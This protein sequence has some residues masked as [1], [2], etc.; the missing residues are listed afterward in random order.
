MLSKSSRRAKAEALGDDNLEGGVPFSELKI[1][2]TISEEFL[3]DENEGIE[4]A[5]DKASGDPKTVAGGDNLEFQTYETVEH[6]PVKYTHYT[7]A[8]ELAIQDGI[9]MHKYQQV[10]DHGSY[11]VNALVVGAGRGPLVQ[12]VLKAIANLNND[13]TCN[14]I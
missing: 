13:Q 8:V 5:V 3:L 7:R 4:A 14:H 2:P 1:G 10:D 9:A 6:D 11:G 12:A